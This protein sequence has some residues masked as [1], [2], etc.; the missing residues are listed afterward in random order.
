MTTP[1][2]HTRRAFLEAASHLACAPA[3]L[4]A[5]AFF[6]GLAL[7]NPRPERPRSL[8]LLELFGGVD[9]LSVLVPKEDD[10]YRRSRPTL[11]FDKS[12]LHSIDDERG[13]PA[14]LAGLHDLYHE[15]HLRIVEGV[16]YPNNSMSH[17]AARVVWGAAYPKHAARS[18]GW[19]ARLRKHLWKDD[20]RP[21]VLTHVGE[22]LAPAL[23]GKD[24]P[25]LCFDRP[26]GLD[27]IA[28]RRAKSDPM[29][30]PPADGEGEQSEDSSS[31]IL[32]ELRGTLSLSKRLAPR[33]RDITT[34]YKPRVEYPNTEL[35]RRLRTI[36]A[37]LDAGFGSRVYSL[38]HRS[39]DTHSSGFVYRIQAPSE[40]DAAIHAFLA[41]LKGTSAFEDT[42]VLCHSEFGRRVAENS[43]GGSDH[44]AAGLS[45][46]LGGRLRGGIS[47][48]RPSLVDLD[49]NGSLIPNVDFRAVYAAVIEQWF[50]ADHEPVMLEKLAVPELI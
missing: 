30:R 39:F 19:I 13:F 45:F 42:L 46:L 22:V 24:L 23:K 21:E 16:G 33:L 25:V 40:F 5:P 36:A 27:W 34:Q 26:E 28:P 2:P 38:Q 44:G 8:V 11:A 32:S 43:A 49:A 18:E 31:D 50:G 14:H 10:V 12:T 3:F 29:Q 7:G 6:P 47:G 37:M 4:P 17:F 15:G 9:G 1:K 20:P 48:K 41:D 35:G